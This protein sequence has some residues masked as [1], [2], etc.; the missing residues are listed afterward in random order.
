MLDLQ[1]NAR[2]QLSASR[3][4]PATRF[5]PHGAAPATPRSSELRQG[6]RQ[7]P[8][9]RDSRT[10]RRSPGFE[11]NDIGFLRRA[12]Q[13]SWNNW[14][15]FFDRQER[16]F[17]NSFR[18]NNN[19]WQYWTSD[20]RSRSSAAY[21]TNLHVTF[22]NNWALAHGRHARP[23]RQ[24]PTTIARPA[25]DRRFGRTSTSRPGSSSTATT[26]K[27]SCPTSTPTSSGATTGRSRRRRASAPASI[28]KLFGRISSSLGL[29][30]SHNID[31]NQWYGT[32]HRSLD[33][34]HYTFAHLDQT[35]TSVTMRAELH[36][37]ARRVAAD[38][39]AAVRVEGHV[40]QRARAVGDAARRRTTTTGT[41]PYRDPS[42]TPIRAD[43]TSRQL[44]S[45]VVF[46]WEYKPGS[47]LFAVWNHGRQGYDGIEGTNSSRATCGICS[48]CIRRT[49]SWSR[50]RTG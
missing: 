20:G 3:R 23:A 35:T 8:H 12:D 25:V 13:I 50:C 24:R 42:V 2:A 11:V 27:P 10:Q 47:T 18:L 28:S 14:V 6:R 22:K 38:V 7:A 15:G 44:Q 30:W 5:Q 34:T 45:N 49:R 41:P 43:S 46:R 16:Y 37:H 17:Y 1:Q 32:V 21:N 39:R 26:G 48:A 9:V 29:N 19:W 33:A 31:D 40:H 36:L 4:R